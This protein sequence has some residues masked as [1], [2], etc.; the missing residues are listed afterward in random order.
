MVQEEVNWLGIV[1]CR[2]LVA[3]AVKEWVYH[4]CRCCTVLC[5]DSA[6]CMGMDRCVDGQY[7]T[8]LASELLQWLKLPS[9]PV[10]Y[11]LV[12]SLNSGILVSQTQ[13][14]SVWHHLFLTRKKFWLQIPT[15][16]D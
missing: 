1:Q 11:Y 14:P 15:R 16:I 9:P 10:V 13:K 4:R 5:L 12:L 8:L 7:C 2:L 6:M 3:C